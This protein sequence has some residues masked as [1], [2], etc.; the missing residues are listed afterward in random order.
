[1]FHLILSG[2]VF[3]FT[4][5][6]VQKNRKMKTLPLTGSIVA[7]VTPFENGLVDK[8]ALRRLVEF[9][10]QQGT[11][12]IVPCGTTGES[13]TL[14][15]KEH[16]EVVDIV[17]QTAA[18]RIPIIAGTGS[19]NTVEAIR[20]TQS[21]LKAGADGALL[22]CPYY[23][24]PTQEGIYLH[25]KAVSESADIPIVLYTIQSRT[26]VNVEPETVARLA[27]L[28][29]IVA[30]KEASGNLEQ[31]SRII[32]LTQGKFPL[33]SG[34]DMLTLPTLS[35]GGVGVISVLANIM[36]REV[37]QL[38]DFFQKGKLEEARAIH[39]RV[40]SLTKSLFVET[41]P[42]P[43]KKALSLLGMIEADVRLPLCQVSTSNAT[44][45]E[46]EMRSVG[47]LV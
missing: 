39:Y 30:M 26:G 41:N 22:I 23:N 28:E 11:Q 32:S 33:L 40:L 46:K 34:D 2:T 24:K 1:M 15:H 12:G 14:S 21:A 9:H 4:D 5:I 35:I 16:E 10:I 36:P 37:S 20:L 17:I 6:R 44:L 18:G 45:I 25:Y 38:I 7:L 13:A 31:M 29:N 42:S 3:T 19:N 43:V 8:D 47:L 27:L